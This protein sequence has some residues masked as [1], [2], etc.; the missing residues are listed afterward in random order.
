MEDRAATGESFYAP[1]HE[2]YSH[3]HG[4]PP[5]QPPFQHHSQ[6]HLHAYQTSL[7]PHY[8]DLPGPLPKQ[9]IPDDAA[10][11]LL[12]VGYTPIPMRTRIA[13]DCQGRQIEYSE[14]GCEHRR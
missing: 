5:A 1:Y 6:P 2:A 11:N 13:K 10:L 3:L 9:H 12:C 8:G 7:H 14:Q 4:Y